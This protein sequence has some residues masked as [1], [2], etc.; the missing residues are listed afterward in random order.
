MATL[1]SE[2]ILFF[3]IGSLFL[4]DDILEN[5]IP[6]FVTLASTITSFLSILVVLV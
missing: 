3:G 2:N 5:Q 1:I 6:N 4:L